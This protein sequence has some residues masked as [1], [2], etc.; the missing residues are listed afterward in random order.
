MPKRK[1]E[2]SSSSSSSSSSKKPRKAE[3]PY[4]E[5]VPEDDC[6][7]LSIDVG[8]VNVGCAL[9]NA[10]TGEIGFANRIT[11]APSMK[12]M[13]KEAEI[14][15]RVYKLFFKEFRPLVDKAALVIV[16]QQMKTKCKLIQYSIGAICMAIDKPYR[17]IGPRSIK[18]FY[19]TGKTSRKGTGSAVKG[20]KNNHAANKK[21][22]IALAMKKWPRIMSKIDKKKQDDVADALL[23]ASWFRESNQELGWKI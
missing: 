13:A 9:M 2:S 6:W 21:A 19:G 16:E 22:A 3:V 12:A 20:T 15:P 18:A 23:Q 11:L 4:L 14:T 8:I 17:Y 5:G 10:K 1:S 7:V